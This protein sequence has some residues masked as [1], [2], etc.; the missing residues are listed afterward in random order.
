MS[1]ERIREVLDQKPFA[2]FTVFTGDGSEVDVIAREFAV[3]YPG[4]RTLVVTAPKYR[5]AWDEGDFETHQIDVFLITKVTT[6]A[7][8]G[9]NGGRRKAS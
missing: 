4:G 7:R 6:P 3:L 5:G 8:R 9:R 2:P 1:P